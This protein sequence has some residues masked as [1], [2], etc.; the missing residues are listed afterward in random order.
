MD[1]WLDNHGGRVDPGQGHEHGEGPGDGDDEPVLY[2]AGVGH[3]LQCHPGHG[4]HVAPS[5]HGDDC[6][7]NQVLKIVK[8]PSLLYH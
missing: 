4:R 2:V 1:N 6:M 5:V 7:L 8:I 3:L